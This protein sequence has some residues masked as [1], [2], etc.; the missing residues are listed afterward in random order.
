MWPGITSIRLPDLPD[1]YYSNGEWST[2]CKVVKH[3]ETFKYCE[4]A[5]FWDHLDRSGKLK[6]RQVLISCD[7]GRKQWNTVMGPLLDP[8]PHGGLWVYSPGKGKE[9]KPK[10]LSLKGYPEGHDFHPLGM[11]IFPSHN[12]NASNL[13]VVNH[14]RQRTFIEQFSLAPH[15]PTEAVWIRT[16]DSTYFVSSNS[17]ALTS[18]TSFYVTNDHLMTRRLP[19]PFGNVLPVMETLL[20]L[21]L[22]WVSH[23]TL[24]ENAKTKSMIVEHAFAAFGIPFSNGIAMSP[25]GKHVAVSSSSLSKVYFYTRDPKNNA[26][27]FTHTVPLPFASDNLMFDDEG[28]LIASGH[29]HFIS[30]IAVAAN[31]TDVVAPSW[32]ASISPRE[33]LGDKAALSQEYDTRAPVSAS[34]KVRAVPSHEVE[35]LFQSNGRFFSTSTTGLRDSRTG[36]LYVPGLYEEGLL[37]CTP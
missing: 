36:A 4:D 27:S 12:G 18:P 32:V 11:D 13:F 6:D 26:L 5:V 37:V 9:S 10:R 1:G 34:T 8:K 21:P 22:T 15:K 33:Q 24:N 31:K 3:D 14:A 29:P 20:T 28:I 17:I 25:N 30:L 16:L 35:T 2:H 19:K 23:I 7:P